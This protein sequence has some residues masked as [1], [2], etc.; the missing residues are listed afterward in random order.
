MFDFITA[1]PNLPFSIALAI[2]LLMALLEGVGTLFG[3][4]FS[5][6]LENLLPDLDLDVDVNLP[7]GESPLALSRLL[8]WL[9]LGQVPA[10]IILIVFLTTFGL[11]G[12]FL[13]SFADRTFGALA[14]G[15]LASI[16]AFAVSLPMVRLFG[17]TL[18]KILPKDE[19]SAVS[20]KTFIGRLATI[21][22]GSARQGSP[23]EARL[24]DQ[25]GQTH[26]LMV[27]PDLDGEEFLQGEQVILVKKNASIFSA[28]RNTSEALVD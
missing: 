6:L 21:T 20:D 17:G 22:L 23:A 9:R 19:T 24:E 12:L 10:L 3:L 5:S 7:E 18:G 8:G 27:E 26:Y 1:G 15:W 13:Q 11:M 25:F 16:A 14:P 28:I 2:M 4:G